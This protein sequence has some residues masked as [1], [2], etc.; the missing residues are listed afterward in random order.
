MGGY[1]KQQHVFQSQGPIQSAAAAVTCAA[2]VRC[3]AI[4]IS[5]N[6]AWLVK[7][8]AGI[9]SSADTINHY[10]PLKRIYC[11]LGP[12]YYDFIQV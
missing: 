6:N 12:L 10:L 5:V 1:E 3:A 11:S 2:P 7:R 9:S 8:P 4:Y